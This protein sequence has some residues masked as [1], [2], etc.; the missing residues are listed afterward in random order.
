MHAAMPWRADAPDTLS[1]SEPGPRP[2][3]FV[4]DRTPIAAF[5][6]P[7]RGRPVVFLHGNSSTKAV[8]KHQLALLA[9]YRR[10]FLALDFPGHGQSANSRTPATSYSFPGYA[11]V[12]SRLIEACGWDSVHVV[13]WSLGGH[14]GLELLAVERRVHSLLIVGTPPVR[15]RPQSLHEAFHADDDMQLAGKPDFTEAD[16]IA[17]G[18]AMMGGMELLTPSLLD[19]IRRTDG[20]ARHWMFKNALGGI[21]TD[22]RETAETCEK[23]LCVVHGGLEPFV[24]LDYLQSLRYRSLFGGSVNVVAAAGHAPHWQCPR[25]FNEI[26]LEFLGLPAASQAGLGCPPKAV[27]PAGLLRR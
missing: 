9:R 1:F 26:L 2:V 17:Y 24:R 19:A 18:M 5:L 20:N 22:Q 11:T 23:P 21:G 14:V 6:S 13:G 27:A 8:W 7:G 10:P 4:V 25:A 12:V 16:A 3:R 15:L